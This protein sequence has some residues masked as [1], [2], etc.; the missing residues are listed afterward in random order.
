MQFDSLILVTGL[1]TFEKRRPLLDTIRHVILI[2]RERKLQLNRKKKKEE[3]SVPEN[4]SKNYILAIGMG[5]IFLKKL[6]IAMLI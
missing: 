5:N 6:H 2:F 1:Y 4:V 3:T